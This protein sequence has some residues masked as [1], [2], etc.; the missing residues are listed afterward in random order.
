MPVW[1]AS[2]AHGPAEPQEVHVFGTSHVIGAVYF[3]A[4]MVKPGSLPSAK[5]FR[6]NR[7]NALENQ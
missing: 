6:G 2:T 5:R 3:V 4:V 7:K 1:M